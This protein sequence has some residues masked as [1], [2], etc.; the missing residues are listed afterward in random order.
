MKAIVEL[1]NPIDNR[2]DFLESLFIL[3]SYQDL[4]AVDPIQLQEKNQSIQNQ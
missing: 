1:Q 3:S 2:L 4:V